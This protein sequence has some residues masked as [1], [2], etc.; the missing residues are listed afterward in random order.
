MNARLEFW[1][2]VLAGMGASVLSGVGTSVSEGVGSRVGEA[3]LYDGWVS[4]RHVPVLIWSG[5]S[6]KHSGL[7]LQMR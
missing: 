2:G 6:I 1:D 3:D 5:H 4:R 7:V